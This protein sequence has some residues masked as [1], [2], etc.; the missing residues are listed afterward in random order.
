MHL[1]QLNMIKT[2]EQLKGIQEFM[3]HTDFLV[4]ENWKI[5]KQLLKERVYRCNNMKMFNQFKIAFKEKNISIWPLK[6]EEIISWFDTLLIL[7]RVI[8]NINNQIKDLNDFYIIV[9]YPLVNGNHMRTDYLIVYSRLIIVL[10]FGM[11]NQD[12]KRSEERYTKKLQES[13]SYRQILANN[14]DPS[15]EIVNYVLI[16]RPEHDWNFNEDIRDNIVYNNYETNR[17]CNYITQKLAKQKNS[18]AI[19]QLEEIEKNR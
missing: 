16:Y 15:I 12:E 6:D 7:R 3:Q 4:D 17:L 10:E 11:F 13:N 14:I 5:E 8:S 9:E 2:L 1:V 19:N 18:L